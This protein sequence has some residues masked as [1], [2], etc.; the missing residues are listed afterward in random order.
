[1]KQIERTLIRTAVGAVLA[2][3]VQPSAFDGTQ[4]LREKRMSEN[5]P[6]K[7]RPFTTAPDSSK[8]WLSDTLRTLSPSLIFG[9]ALRWVWMYAVIYSAFPSFFISNEATVYMDYPPGNISTIFFI[10][11]TFAM[12]ALGEKITFVIRQ[13]NVQLFIAALLSAGTA[14]FFFSEQFFVVPVTVLAEMVIGAASGFLMLIWGEAYRRRE[15]PAIVLNSILGISGGL[16]LFRLIIY[17]LS[18]F[19]SCLA[20]T[21]IPLAEIAFLL[22]ALHGSKALIHPQQFTIEADGSKIAAPGLLEIPTFHKLRVRKSQFLVRMGFP[23]LLFGLALGVLCQHVFGFVTDL[24]NKALSDVLVT[25]FLPGCIGLVL[26]LAFLRKTRDENYGSYY[27]YFIPILGILVLLTTF[28]GLGLAGSVFGLTAYLCFEFMMWV[29]CCIISHRYRISPILVTGFGRAF[30]VVG[31]FLADNLLPLAPFS[32]T[33]SSYSA[34]AYTFIIVGIITGYFLLPHKKDI[35]AMSILDYPE[36][37][38]IAQPGESDPDAKDRRFIA[39]CNHVANTYLLS[40]R[41]TEVFYLLAKGRNAA[42]IAKTLYISEGTVHTHTW[43]IYKKLDVHSQQELMDM[44]DA[45]L[46]DKQSA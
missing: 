43:R 10:A 38:S 13:R 35:K 16:V 24:G 36:S 6:E 41:E 25:T 28:E 17:L 12:G 1:M 46:S 30:L 29:E 5:K 4:Q 37:S 31:M 32:S 33:F 21:L 22:S 42:H 18:P 9:F 45:P 40:S 44:V 11:T 27:R 7:L 19:L 8:S 15:P 14:F 3:K 2:G 26:V 23:F 39:R 20:F 34:T